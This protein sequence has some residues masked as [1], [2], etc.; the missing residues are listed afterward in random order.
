MRILRGEK[1]IDENALDYE[2]NIVDEQVQRKAKAKNMHKAKGDQYGSMRP[3]Q[4]D[5]SGEEFLQ[6]ESGDVSLNDSTND[7]IDIEDGEEIS[8]EELGEGEEDVDD[9]EEDM[10]NEF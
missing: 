3:Q 5:E 6:S 2:V 4:D 1:E 7:L 10:D 8:G 9:D